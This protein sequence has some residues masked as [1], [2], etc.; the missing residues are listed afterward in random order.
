M[1]SEDM[2]TG[3]SSNQQLSH[4]ARSA[5]VLES[6][7]G[8]VKELVKIESKSGA[9]DMRTVGPSLQLNDELNKICSMFWPHV[10]RMIEDIL[11]TLV[12]P[13][14]HDLSPKLQGLKFTALDLS[15][16]QPTI[17]LLDVAKTDGRNF[18]LIVGVEHNITKR[19]ELSLGL[20]NAKIGIENARVAGE[21]VVRFD[22]LLDTIPLVGGIAIQLADLP[23]IDYKLTG[24]AAVAGLP[25]LKGMI[26]GVIDS[27]IADQLL[28]PNRFAVSWSDEVDISKLRH[29]MPAGMLQVM[30]GD[31][32]SLASALQVPYKRTSQSAAAT[33]IDIRLGSAERHF[34]MLDESRL[35]NG[36]S[37]FIVWNE[38]QRIYASATDTWLGLVSGSSEKVDIGRRLGEIQSIPVR[39]A[40]RL[41]QAQ[42]PFTKD[43][44]QD[45]LGHL[46]IAFKML[47]LVPAMKGD[48][49]MLK[50]HVD[51]LMLPYKIQS[52][53]VSVVVQMGDHKEF[54]GAGSPRQEQLAVAEELETVMHSMSENGMSTAEIAKIMKVDDDVVNKVLR[55]ESHANLHASHVE[56][57]LDSIVYL[58]LPKR[59]WEHGETTVDIS[60]VSKEQKGSP[61]ASLQQTVKSLPF[62]DLRPQKIAMDSTECS[63]TTTKY[64]PRDMKG[65]GRTQEP[66]LDA[67]QRRCARTKGCAHFSYWKVDGGCHLQDSNAA[68]RRD[69]LATSGPPHCSGFDAWL[70]VSLFG[71]EA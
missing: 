43:D 58:P 65:Q 22:H 30:L 45:G 19:Q 14:L 25:G 39:E 54:T 35:A 4:V 23:T 52:R 61:L 17:R 42:L 6:V 24:L 60:V 56:L 64:M 44:R 11:Q 21:V 66:S 9:L 27:V 26:A 62:G 68:E 57:V 36:S 12:L 59:L 63:R 33:T 71:T 46:S 13:L 69:R 51:H 53:S 70:S 67:C 40:L 18:R 29:P 5:E 50:V 2:Q 7:S 32:V 31:G 15:S 8:M 55:G 49:F 10:S 16:D 47:Q 41:G 38:G 20:A 28:G 1:Q 48:V 37:A 3:T 34:E